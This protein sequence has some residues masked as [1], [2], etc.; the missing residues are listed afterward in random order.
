MGTFY[1][2][3]SVGSPLVSLSKWGKNGGGDSVLSEVEQ[4]CMYLGPT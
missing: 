4:F 3:L 1:T 2:L